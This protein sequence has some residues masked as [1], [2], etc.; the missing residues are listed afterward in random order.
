MDQKGGYMILSREDFEKIV[1]DVET[2]V[3][4]EY[5]LMLM[6]ENHY[7]R[8]NQFKDQ[9]KLNLYEN[10]Y[11]KAARIMNQMQMYHRYNVLMEV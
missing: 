1:E 7:R 9:A 8:G 4:Y 10:E 2:V 11:D 6:I 5:I 3:D